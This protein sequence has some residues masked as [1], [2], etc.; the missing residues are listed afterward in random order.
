MQISCNLRQGKTK[1]RNFLQR[2]LKQLII[3]GFKVN[4]PA[5][6]QYLPVFFQKISMGQTALFLVAFGPWITEIDIKPVHLAGCKQFRQKGGIC[7]NEEHIFKPFIFHPFHSHHHGVRYFFHGN[8]QGVRLGRCRSGGEAALAAAQLH[9]QFFRLW[10][11]AA[12]IA[13]QGLG[14]GDQQP[15]AGFHPGLQVF[16]FSHAHVD[17]LPDL[18]PGREAA[19]S[20]VTTKYVLL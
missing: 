15:A 8:K 18:A 6:F 13:A 7:I 12:P 9:L 17:F 19:S 16:L 2:P 11:Q 10:K 4:L 1:L 3:V 5:R 14:L 20:H